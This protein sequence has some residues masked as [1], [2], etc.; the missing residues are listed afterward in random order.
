MRKLFEYALPWPLLGSDLITA[1]DDTNYL[2]IQGNLRGRRVRVP[3]GNQHSVVGVI[4]KITLHTEYDP[5]KL[6]SVLEVLD[7]HP[8]FPSTSLELLTWA[9]EYYRHPIGDAILQSLPPSLKQGKPLLPPKVEQWF[10]A[11]N[12][13]EI[14]HPIR[15]NATKLN[16][17]LE[18]LRASSAP[19]ALSQL[20][21]KGFTAKQLGQLQGR[22]LIEEVETS[23]SPRPTPK[24]LTLREEQRHA[25]LAIDKAWHRFSPFLLQGVTGSGKTEVYI[26]L[27]ES[28]LLQAMQVLVLIPEINLTPQTFLRFQAHFPGELSTLHH[29]GLSETEKKAAW[30]S[31]L[32]N[33]TKILIGTRSAI[34]YPFQKLGVIIVDEEHDA[35]FKQQ[36]GF[37]YSARDLALLLAQKHRCPVVLGSAT[38]SLESLLNVKIGKY[39]LLTLKERH[40][41][42]TL[43]T[44]LL[45]DLNKERMRHGISHT[46]LQKTRDHLAQGNQVLYFINRKGF[47]PALICHDCQ[48]IA[49]CEHCDTRLTYYKKAHQL[50]CQHCGTNYPPV[51]LCPSCKSLNLH[52]TGEGTERIEEVLGGVFPDT[53]IFRI[54]RDSTSHRTSMHELYKE[55]RQGNPCILVGTQML[56]KGHDFP[57]LTLVGVLAADDGL[58]SA[59]Y[60]ASER[61]TQLLIQVAGRAGRG[62]IQG[63]VVIQTRQPDLPLIQLICR[64]DY[65]QAAERL[66]QERAACELPPY[67]ASACIKADSQNP[68]ETEFTLKAIQSHLNRPGTALTV[69]GPFT[70][71]I[72]RKA[73][74]FRQYLLLQCPSRQQ[75]QQVLD[76]LALFRESFRPPKG[77]KIFIDVDPL[78]LS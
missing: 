36:E 31:I 48:W 40:S 46:L 74:R 70:P 30:Y 38:P 37:R 14:Q 45:A 5:E 77:V 64:L 66:L 4:L 9:A 21:S 51:Y 43:P 65:N 13:P 11:L 55:V 19:L 49:G 44:V 58:Y 60:R 20:R 6:K 22:K 54:D 75:V 68:E 71:P 67:T 2:D 57:R 3:F 52:A 61:V 23:E 78:D 27:A 39:Q 47:A 56:A 25:Y 76:Q 73:N 7:V 12:T 8:I 18:T 26:K 35:S 16:A 50:R 41:K 1:S 29:S 10:R 34:F 24:P 28:A 63:E 53:P 42:A 32:H 17:L 33:Q 69:V 72:Q 59:D 15:S 62:L